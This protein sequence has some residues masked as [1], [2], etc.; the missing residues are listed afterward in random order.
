MAC[1]VACAKQPLAATIQSAHLQ[2]HFFVTEKHIFGMQKGMASRNYQKQGG[3]FNYVC[4]LLENT[5][6]FS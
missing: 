4:T 6:V 5:Y 2:N 3:L 1:S